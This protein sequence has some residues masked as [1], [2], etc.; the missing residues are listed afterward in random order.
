M[1]YL[2]SWLFVKCLEQLT[3]TLTPVDSTRTLAAD[4]ALMV[5]V[6]HCCCALLSRRTLILCGVRLP[7]AAL[8][9]LSRPTAMAAQ[10]QQM[11]QPQQT[12]QAQGM[13]PQQQQK[14]QPQRQPLLQ[15]Q[16]PSVML[17]LHV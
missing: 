8:L 6:L 1:Q 2:C 7:V 14:Q 13:L 16:K 3:A 10:Q 11:K 17:M 4:K 5:P 12:P 9:Q 15:Q